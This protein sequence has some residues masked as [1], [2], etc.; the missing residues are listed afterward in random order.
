MAGRMHPRL[1]KAAQA[2]KR[3]ADRAGIE[4]RRKDTGVRR[5][6]EAVLAHAKRLGFQPATVIDVGVAYGTPEL[7]DAF[8]DAR[9]LLVDPLEEYAEGIGQITSRL[10][11][12]EWVRAAAGPAPGELEIVVNRAPALS[13]TLGHWKGQDDGGQARTVPVVRIDDLVTE[14]SLPAPFLVKADV[15]GAELRVLDGATRVLE[16]TELVL[17]EV[18][19]FQFLPG[20]PQLHDVVVYMKERGFVTYDFYGGHVRLLD[21]ALAMTNMAFVREDG[22]F[23][24]SHDFATEEQAREMY[25]G[26]GF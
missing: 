7:Y 4:V 1:K 18:N 9:F 6:P 25:E 10:R 2:A 13:S 23:R 16:Q 17:L 20:Q 8:P 19:L 3:L 5:T 12:A 22:R 21:D 11:D 15:E 14:R 26:W 24:R